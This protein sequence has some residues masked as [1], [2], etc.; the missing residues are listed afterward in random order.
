ML[1]TKLLRLLP[2][3]ALGAIIGCGREGGSTAEASSEPVKLTFSPEP[4]VRSGYVR[5]RPIERQPTEPGSVEWQWRIKGAGLPGGA[6]FYNSRV[7]G[8]GPVEL[9]MQLSGSVG[10]DARVLLNLT[11][12]SGQVRAR[13]R[14]EISAGKDLAKVEEKTWTV[15]GNL[16]TAVRIEQPKLVELEMPVRA[17]FATVGGQEVAAN[18]EQSRF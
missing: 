7:T 2:L 11:E 10:F 5:I 14:V 13:Q 3:L 17:K 6:K 12:E 16:K 8:H 15:P 9:N 1:V 18:F 4:G